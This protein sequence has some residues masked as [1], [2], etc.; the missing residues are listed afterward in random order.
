MIVRNAIKCL[1]CNDIVES[2]HRH[3]FQQCFCGNVFVDGGYD[4]LR[5]GVRDP[6]A[7]LSLV[8]TDND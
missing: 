7:Y 4:Y 5:S 2:T 6:S 1:L 3:D 8:E